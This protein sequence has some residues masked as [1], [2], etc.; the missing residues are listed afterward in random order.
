MF[1]YEDDS[2]LSLEFPLVQKFSKMQVSPPIEV[3]ELQKVEK[4]LQTL[5]DA[6]KLKGKIE[7]ATSKAKLLKDESWV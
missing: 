3:E 7:I 4:T 1:Y 2:K 6:L 5:R